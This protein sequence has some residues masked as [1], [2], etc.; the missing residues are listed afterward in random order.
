MLLYCSGR[1]QDQYEVSFP[2]PVEVTDAETLRELA[3]LSD[4]CMGEFRDGYTQKGRFALAHLAAEDFICS[5]VLYA[6]ID[7]DGCSPSTQYT[8]KDFERD[9]ARW[10]YYITTSKSHQ[11]S[12]H[13]DP[14]LDRFHVLFPL[15]QK[16]NQPDRMKS[17]LRILY[18]HLFGR[19]TIDASCIDVARKFYGNPTNE[20]YHHVGESIF[21]V[22]D[23]LWSRESKEVL[24]T[25]RPRTTG[26]EEPLI[27]ILCP[28]KGLVIPSLDKAYKLGWFDEYRQWLNLA[29]ALKQAGFDREVWLRY[30]HT[31]EDAELAIK[32]WD[33]INPDGSIN[34]MQYLYSIHEKLAFS[35]VVKGKR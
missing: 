12:K 29:V 1:M 32:K 4:Y 31:A 25:D 20:S 18:R 6:D 2:I 15:G 16:I 23:A 30:C 34:G 13:D 7:N 24:R 9:F 35:E 21:N 26:Q 3:A 22:I 33:T 5:D 17:Y 8:I 19:Q 10:E 11:K 14:P 28:L 27:Q